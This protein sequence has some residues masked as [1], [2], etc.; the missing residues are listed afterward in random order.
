MK[1]SELYPREV[2]RTALF[3]T[4]ASLKPNQAPLRDRAPPMPLDPPNR[5]HKVPPMDRRLRTGN[6]AWDKIARPARIRGLRRGGE[7]FDCPEHGN[8]GTVVTYTY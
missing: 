3:V 7:G 1:S 2:G 6:P 4:D 8:D 5:I